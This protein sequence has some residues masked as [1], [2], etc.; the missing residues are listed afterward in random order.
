[1]RTFAA[2]WQSCNYYLMESVNGSVIVSEATLRLF[3]AHNAARIQLFTYSPI[4][5]KT[6]KTWANP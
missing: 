4:N 6:I 5:V 3:A 1:M 2:K